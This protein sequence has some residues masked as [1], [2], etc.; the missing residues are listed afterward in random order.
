MRRRLRQLIRDE[1]GHILPLVLVLVTVGGLTIAPMLADAATSL[2]N[3]QTVEE[4]IN[5]MFAA[6]AGIEYVVWCLD[7][8]I[9]PPAQLPESINGMDVSLAVVDQGAFTLYFGELIQAG[10]H[11]THLDV[12]G[13]IVWDEG[14][15]A[16][17]YTITVTWQ[18]DAGTPVIHLEE[19]GASVP[20]GFN[21]QSD[22]AASFAGNLSTGEPDQTAE[23]GGGWLLNWV[24]SPPHPSVSESEPV[25]TQTFYLT[26]AGDLDGGY[27]WVIASREDIGAA[28][29]VSGNLYD[30]TVT[31]T[32]SSTGEV[33]SVVT[34]GAVTQAGS[35]DIVSWTVSQ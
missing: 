6:D 24:L 25:R 10:S 30:I 17:K 15:S 13:T 22:S 26:G 1:T 2:K 32:R 18:A 4:G 20:D 27:A 21:Y 11:S 35:V 16:Y 33:A 23:A 3:S 19:V 5:G 7:N 14:A 8:S 9:T 29:E 34:A 31:A 12:D 28:G